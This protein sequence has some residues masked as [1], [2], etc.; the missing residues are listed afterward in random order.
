MV[1]VIIMSSLLGVAL[2]VAF[3]LLK[4]QEG[5]LLIKSKTPTTLIRYLEG[6]FLNSQ[7]EISRN[8]KQL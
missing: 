1:F 5:I 3:S 8:L 4:G 7:G 6:G 2:Y